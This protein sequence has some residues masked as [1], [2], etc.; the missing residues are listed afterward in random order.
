MR[1]V[2]AWFPIAPLHLLLAFSGCTVI[3]NNNGGQVQ[4]VEI[5]PASVTISIGV[6]QQFSANVTFGDG[7]ILV[8]KNANVLWSTSDSKI[9]TVDFNGNVTGMTAGMA[10]ITGTFIN[11]SGSAVVT[12]TAAGEIHPQISGTAEML[13]IVFPQR[14]KQFIYAAN[15]LDDSITM[16]EVNLRTGEEHSLGAASVVSAHQPVW[17]AINPSGQFLFVANHGSS[18]I[19]AF[20]I[21]LASGRSNAVTGSPFELEVAPW[22]V[23]VD[24][25]GKFLSVSHFSSHAVSHF[26]IAP[27]SGAL[28]PGN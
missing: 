18:S 12:V 4:S 19:S 22:S 25:E 20:T 14:G 16:S 17:L 23:S 2:L 3:L 11:V 28:L 10:T 5:T 9:A 15:P 7:T 21:D 6:K 8:E 24:A 26:R 13:S 27:S 1:R